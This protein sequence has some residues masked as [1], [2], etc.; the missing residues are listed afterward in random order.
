MTSRSCRRTSPPR[1]PLDRTRLR[2]R[3]AREAPNSSPLTPP[4]CDRLGRLPAPG[5]PGRHRAASRPPAE[6]RSTLQ[7][8]GGA[9]V[10]R[11]FRRRPQR[12]SPRVSRVSV[13]RV[14]SRFARSRTGRVLWRQRASRSPIFL[15][16]LICSARARETVRRCNAIVRSAAHSAS[17]AT[18]GGMVAKM[19]RVVRLVVATGLLAAVTGGG[20]AI[21]HL[22]APACGPASARTIAGII[23][24]AYTPTA[25]APTAASPEEAAPTA[26]GRR[27]SASRLGARV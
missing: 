22:A 21:A 15:D 8:A 14:L 24:P 20:R 18:V 16:L 10:V 11:A 3:R 5:S 19:I 2:R 13:G 17:G 1:A 9:A 4:R 7:D 23:S 12:L 26:S 25:V 6:R 27:A